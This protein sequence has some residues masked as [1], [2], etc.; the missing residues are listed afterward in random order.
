MDLYILSPIRLHGVVLNY[1]STGK[2]TGKQGS[3]FFSGTESV[4]NFSLSANLFR[5]SV[6][7]KQLNVDTF[8]PEF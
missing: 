2:V 8:C 4:L 3:T 1:L 6:V 5:D 7:P